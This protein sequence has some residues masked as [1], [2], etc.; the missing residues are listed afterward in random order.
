MTTKKKAKRGRPP[1]KVK[2]DYTSDINKVISE[3]IKMVRKMQ[4][5]TQVQFAERLQTNEPYIKAI[6]RGSFTPSNVFLV[7]LAK[8]FKVNL[9]WLFGLIA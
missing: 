7:N 3:R 6:E 8:E 5:L 2:T 1:G 9:N 4:G